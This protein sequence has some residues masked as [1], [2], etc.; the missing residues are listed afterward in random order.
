MLCNMSCM[1]KMIASHRATCD[2]I[3][4]ALGVGL[5][6]LVANTMVNK[7]CCNHDLKKKA[8]K[9]FKCLEDKLS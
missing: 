3:G 6:F 5:G 2:I 1:K 9:A 8:K 7:C 4:V